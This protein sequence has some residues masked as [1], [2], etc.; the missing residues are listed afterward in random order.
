MAERG[1]YVAEDG[2][3]YVEGEAYTLTFEDEFEGTELDATKWDRCPEQKRQ[4]LECYWNNECAI[5]K[6]DG[7]LTITSEYR[8]GK[9]YMG[10][11]RS[12]R[13]FA[14]TYGYYEVCCTLNNVPG[15]WVAFWLMGEKVGNVDNSGVD[16][17]EVDIMESAFF[18]EGI[19]HALHWDGYGEFHKTV[20]KETMNSK[21]YDGEYHTF[22]LLWTEKEY[23]FYI[24]RKETWRTEAKEAGGTCQAPLYLKFTAET[25]TWT[26]DLLDTSKFP[27]EVYVDYVRVYERKSK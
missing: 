26:G 2:T 20:G 27:T 1:I 24:D 21:V 10:G 16:G 22:S 23:I 12:K 5:L 9:Y 18:G 25:G 17:T 13:K 19:N 4:D 11:I 14:Q 6:G 8:D 7:K 15:Y 3:L